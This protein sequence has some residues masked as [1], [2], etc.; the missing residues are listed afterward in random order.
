VV[1]VALL[2]AAVFGAVI[3]GT[4]LLSVHAPPEGEGE[5]LS[6][7]FAVSGRSTLMHYDVATFDAALNHI[8]NREPE[9]ESSEATRVEVETAGCSNP[10]AVRI[11]V[12]LDPRWLRAVRATRLHEVLVL[13]TNYYSPGHRTF[14]VPHPNVPGLFGLAVKGRIPQLHVEMIAPDVQVS[15]SAEYQGRQSQEDT[16]V[17]GMIP[18]AELKHITPNTDFQN[19]LMRFVFLAPWISARG[20]QS[21]FL[22]LPALVGHSVP[23]EPL[24]ADNIDNA[25][26]RSLGPGEAETEVNA[27][28]SELDLQ[29]SN[30][31]PN[32]AGPSR[33]WT[34][35]RAPER[36]AT[37]DPDCHAAVAARA[38]P[39]HK[40]AASPACSVLPASTNCSTE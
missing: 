34:C 19:G 21:C 29:A 38:A 32:G 23:K 13:H 11:T 10:V 24:T 9:L 30:P 25:S 20:Y 33:Q 31:A 4:F 27:I 35:S 8:P 15:A 40:V 6:V 26:A 5:H 3:A 12:Q 2:I 1:Y 14:T 36:D 28:A 37:H 18:N 7:A 39:R 16:V 22:R 17:T